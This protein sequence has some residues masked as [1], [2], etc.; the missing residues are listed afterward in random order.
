MHYHLTQDDDMNP[1]VDVT[2]RKCNLFS[3]T[4]NRFFYFISDVPY[5]LKTARN[6]LS[7]SG[8]DKCTRYM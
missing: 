4:A 1:G 5:L 3:G 2:Y 6:Y 8:S 7:N